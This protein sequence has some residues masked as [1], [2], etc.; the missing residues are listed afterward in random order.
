[1]FLI[2]GLGNPGAEY[3]ATR[4]NVGFVVVDSLARRCGAAVEQKQSN[5]HIG[6][7]RLGSSPVL[8]AKPMTFMNLSAGPTRALSDFYKVPLDKLVVVHDDL[9][10]PFGTVRVKQGG[11]HGGHNGLRDLH[12]HLGS[13]FVRVRVGISRPPAGWDTA[14]YVLARWSSEE[15]SQLDSV[16]ALAGDAVERVVTDGAER[17]M[18]HFNTVREPARAER[19]C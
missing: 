11:G 19:V 10:L 13:E 9:D 6:K 8:F 15:A 17:A 4:H 3:A 12:K 5:A 2:V 14:A 18:N 7:A 1:M 16:L